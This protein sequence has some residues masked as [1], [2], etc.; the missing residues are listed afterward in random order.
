MRTTFFTGFLLV[1]FSLMPVQAQGSITTTAAHR[2]AI[3]YAGPGETYLQLSKLLPGV[4]V[5]IVERNHIGNWLRVQ[6]VNEQGTTVIDGWVMSGYL[7]LNPDLRFSEVPVSNLPDADPTTVRSQ[8]LAKLYS[9]PIIPK[10]SNTMTE[11]YVRGQWLG[12]DRHTI[13]KVGD[14]LS[15]SKIYL[16]PMSRDDDELGAYDYLEETIHHFGASAALPSVASRIGMSSLVVFDPMWATDERCEAGESPLLCEY[17]LKK[18]IIAL[19]LFGPNDVLSMDTETYKA[20]MTK[21]V[22][23]SLEHGV[24]PVLSTFSVYPEYEY[25]WQSINFNIALTEIAEEYEVPLMNLWAAARPLPDYGLDEDG[26]HLAH[27]GFDHLKFDTGHETWYGVS[28]QNLL[29]IRTLDEIR[30]ALN[31]G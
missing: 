20:Q 10:V 22:E 1:L 18:P 24:I 31:I 14:S 4:E 8:S 23:T 13:T 5:E 27:S 11:V 9:V 7:T 21:I 30:R 25:W 6:L 12:N 15:A 19:I 28:L 29:A 16:E 26:I 2:E 3:V 17:R